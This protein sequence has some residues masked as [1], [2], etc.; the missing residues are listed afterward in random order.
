[1]VL[2]NTSIFSLF[3]SIKATIIA[4]FFLLI[5]LSPSYCLYHHKHKSQ[6]YTKGLLGEKK[7]RLGSIPP[8]CYNKCNQCHPCMAVQVPTTLS[9]HPVEPSRVKDMPMEYFDS[10]S[11]SIGANRYSNYKPLGWKCRCDNH[12]YNP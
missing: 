8:S 4:L 2:S 3:F 6:D 9:H 10:S 1:M 7:T 5:F 11:P 12:F